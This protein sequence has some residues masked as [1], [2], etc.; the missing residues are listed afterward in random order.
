MGCPHVFQPEKNGRDFLTEVVGTKVGS[1]HPNHQSPGNENYE[2][3][4]LVIIP[5]APNT[6]LEGV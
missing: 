3:N 4:P 5:S 1:A 2:R 6:L